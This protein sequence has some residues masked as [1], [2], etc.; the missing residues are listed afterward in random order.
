[1]SA[2]D[3]PLLGRD[4][5]FHAWISGSASLSFGL[6]YEREPSP[7]GLEVA[8]STGSSRDNLGFAFPDRVAD[9]ARMFVDLFDE[10]PLPSEYEGPIF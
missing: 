9:V 5:R 8:S 10:E 6:L 2:L 1:M 7:E 4:N 3:S